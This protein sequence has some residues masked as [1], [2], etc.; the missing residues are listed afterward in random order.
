MEAPGARSEAGACVE[1]PAQETCGEC[2][3]AA[4]VDPVGAGLRTCAGAGAAWKEEACG[5]GLR[6][7]GVLADCG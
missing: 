3:R 7:P 2:V 5:G 6:D 1:A 4:G